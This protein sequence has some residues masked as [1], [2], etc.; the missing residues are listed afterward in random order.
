MKST[1]LR[2][3]HEII[4]ELRNK[5][6]GAYLLRKL[7]DRLM[8][9]ATL[10]GICLFALLLGG[11]LWVNM[12][13][14]QAEMKK[15]TQKTV[16]IK[17]VE[18][19]ILEAAKH[20]QNTATTPPEVSTVKYLPPELAKDN[21]V[22]EETPT[23]KD[24]EKA[25]ASNV[26][27]KGDSLANVNQTIPDQTITKNVGETKTEN[28]ENTIVNFAE[29]NPEYPGGMKEMGKFLS[30]NIRYPSIARKNN[31]GGKVIVSFV[32]NTNGSIQDVNI[33]KGVGYGCDE[34]AK[35]V[36]QKMPAWKPGR[37]GNSPVRVRYTLPIVFTLQN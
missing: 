3:I 31:K 33:L 11:Y 23:Q 6:Y 2:D 1:T 5:D 32:V 34:E 20:L 10:A 12:I 19:P 13:Q 24:L 21:E 36:V 28:T 30:K 18:L 22:K 9:L 27:K 35:R 25:V 37:Q 7:Y 4:F 17:E 14:H 8:F 26:T 15:D 29:Q 16:E